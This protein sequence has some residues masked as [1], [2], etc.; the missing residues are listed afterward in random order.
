MRRQ[1]G[2]CPNGDWFWVDS[3]LPL[4]LHFSLEGSRQREAR[5]SR[6]NVGREPKV[7]EHGL[8]CAVSPTE[9]KGMEKVPMKPRQAPALAGDL[10]FFCDDSPSILLD[11]YI[12]YGTL[13]INR[14]QGCVRMYL[15]GELKMPH[16][17]AIF[18]EDE[19]IKQLLRRH[20]RVIRNC[21]ACYT[22]YSFHEIALI[23]NMVP[24]DIADLADNLLPLEFSIDAGVKCAGFEE[25]INRDVMAMLLSEIPELGTMNFGIW[26]RTMTSNAFIEHKP[27]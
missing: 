3:L 15:T 7:L 13:Y 19:A 12:I 10:L 23:P 20:K 26:L 2:L 25:G 9:G 5:D 11:D 1:H 27:T 24:G 17:H 16:I 14:A 6:R 18:I 8:V 21:V 4:R 22:G